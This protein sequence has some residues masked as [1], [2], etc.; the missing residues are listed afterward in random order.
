MLKTSE[1]KSA[2]KKDSK[3]KCSNNRTISVLANIDK[4][5]KRITYNSLY[6]V[7][8]MNSVIYDLQFGFRQKYSASHN[9][10]YLTDKI[11]EQLGGGNFACEIS[12]DLQKAFET[13]DHDILLQK[14][15]HC[16]MLTKLIHPI[17][18]CVNFKN[19]CRDDH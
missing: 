5:L 16:G 14:L 11:R 1:V 4:V 17:G 19:V 12:F 9:L 10:I 2:Y 8:E 15:N 13:E 6:N 7:L 18:Y 3:L